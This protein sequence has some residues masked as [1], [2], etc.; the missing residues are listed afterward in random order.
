MD[1]RC[2]NETLKGIPL[3]GSPNTTGDSSRRV[4]RGGSWVNYPWSV[5]AGYRIWNGTGDRNNGIGFRV[6]RTLFYPE[7]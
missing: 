5:R 6:A 3:D 2:F 4:V 7:S 1:S